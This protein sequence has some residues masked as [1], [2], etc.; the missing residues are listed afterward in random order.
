MSN[1]PDH[2]VD[3]VA[4]TEEVLAADMVVEQLLDGVDDGSLPATFRVL[5]PIVA[6][7]RRP[8]TAGELAREPEM[9][10][11]FQ[12]VRPAVRHAPARARR[13]SLGVRI[14]V[15]AG[16][17]SVSTAT[18]AAAVGRLPE[19]V[20]ETAAAVLAKVGI[21]V[22]AADT[23]TVDPVVETPDDVVPAVPTTPDTAAAPPAETTAAPPAEGDE[24]ALTS[25][26]PN[27][28]SPTTP[29]PASE[30]E[31]APPDE[32]ADD[33]RAQSHG[34]GSHPANPDAPGQSRAPGQVGRDYGNDAPKP[35]NGRGQDQPKKNK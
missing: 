14:V 19:P 24:V 27:A 22:P 20:Q 10:A 12:A 32:A 6:A 16:L 3:P 31:I 1:R 4:E 30:L 35:G 18:A 15:V 7:A 28:T 25:D 17:V 29:V 34:A 2:D 33:G 23:P 9:A 11:M 26:Q 5:L 8:A 13:R 21:S